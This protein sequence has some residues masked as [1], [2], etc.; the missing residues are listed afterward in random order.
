M[1]IYIYVLCTSPNV[2]FLHIVTFWRQDCFDAWRR[3]G[4]KVLI[5]GAPWS[6]TGETTS[7]TGKLW[8]SQQKW[9]FNVIYSWFMRAELLNITPITM[10]YD[11]YNYHLYI[12]IYMYTVIFASGIY[13]PLIA[14]FHGVVIWMPGLRELHE[15]SPKVAEK[16]H[17]PLGALGP[18][19][20]GHGHGGIKI[21]R[22]KL[23]TCKTCHVSSS[24]TTIQFWGT[25]EVIMSHNTADS[26]KASMV[27]AS[28]IL[29]NA[30]SMVHEDVV[31]LNER[32]PFLLPPTASI[33]WDVPIPDTSLVCPML[34]LSPKECRSP[35]T[36]AFFRKNGRTV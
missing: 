27:S 36:K 20:H 9:G 35:T 11:T 3:T 14:G 21:A 10:V 28:C 4:S 33:P 2:T 8:F 30:K 7:Q 6:S 17:E 32:I 22:W 29:T 1:Y 23:W 16:L 26:S 13:N 5:R 19:G 18:L 15:H 31:S 12:Y 24:L 34:R 25:F